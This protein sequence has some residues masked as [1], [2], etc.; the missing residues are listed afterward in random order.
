MDALNAD[1]LKTSK[2]N[3]F[4]K[5]SLGRILTNRKYIGEYTVQGI[6]AVSECPAIV[7]RDIFE[8]V[9]KRLAGVKRKKRHNRV[10]LLTGKLQCGSCGSM[11]S[12]T[13]GTAKN[14]TVYHYYKCSCGKEKPVPQEKLEQEILCAI[15]GYL[16]KE[17]IDQIA[18][19]AYKLYQSDDSGN[20]EKKAMEQQLK[21]CRKKIQNIVNAIMAGTASAALQEALDGLE[22]EKGK[23]EVAIARA[24]VQ[25]PNFEKEH[26]RYFLERYAGADITDEKLS[27]QVVETLVNKVILYSDRIAVLIN[28][29][30]NANTPPLEQITQMMGCSDNG[31][32]GD[33]Y[34][35]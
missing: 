7:N 15:G 35:N 4:N 19:T 9:Q 23:L 29:T 34:G 21:E 3:A 1:G 16:S 30:N 11:M 25:K 14:G 6:D 12:G 17:K 5:N 28:L 26:F 2:G 8:A 10:C 22:Q 20:M 31:W 18:E 13:A 24:E 32:N 27:V 33:P